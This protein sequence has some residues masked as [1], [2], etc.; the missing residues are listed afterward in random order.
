MMNDVQTDIKNLNLT[1]I[2]ARL[3]KIKTSEYLKF[4]GILLEDHR[5]SVQKLG[6]GLKKKHEALL[7]EIKRVEG[8]HQYEVLGKK[9]GYTLIGGLDEVGRGPL[10]G[11]VVTACV[12]LPEKACIMYVNDSK[13]LSKKRR[14]SVYADIMNQAISYGVGL[15]EPEIIDEINIL[16][17]TKLAMKR[18]IENM[19]I[20]PDC[21][22]ID[23]LKLEDVSIPQKSIIKGDEKSISIASASIIA[24]VTRDNLMAELHKKYPYYDLN[25]NMGYGTKAHYEGLAKHGVSP[26]HRRSFL[27]DFI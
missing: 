9:T 22:L 3:S 25:H 1:E 7:A 5:V 11:P 21:L 6:Q 13:K 12:I 15:V 16:N 8:L 4:S 19:P 27:K 26:I 17:A 18:A 24:K 10:C 2:K 14:E 23:A 20:K